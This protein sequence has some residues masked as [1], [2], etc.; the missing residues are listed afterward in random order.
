M[1]LGLIIYGRLDTLS[2]GYLYDRRLVAYLRGQGD[3]VEIISLPWSGYGRH[4]TH[5]FSRSLFDRLRHAS[6]D[7]LLQDE[8]NHPS[9]FWM[10]QRLREATAYPLISIVHHLRAS[11][12]RPAW[13]NRA[14]GWVEG[15]Y[16]NTVDGFIYNSQTTKTAVTQRLRTQKPSVIAYPAGDRFAPT[17]A[18]AEIA[19]RAQEEGPLRLVFVGNLIP[20]KGLHTLLAALTLLPPES[21]ELIVVGETAVNPTYA[22]TI[23]RQARQLNGPVRF[24]G[25]I[26]DA[27]LAQQL[28]QS[29]LLVVPSDYEGFGI[30]YLEGMGFGLPAIASTAGAAREIITDGVDGFLVGVGETAVLAN[31]IL[32]LHKDR[33]CLTQMG[34]AALKRYHA[35]PTWD[36]SMAKIRQF[37]LSQT[38]NRVFMKN[39]VSPM[40]G[41]NDDD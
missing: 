23:E 2:G 12:A 10:N 9:L 4:L 22:R 19:S 25:A 32:T 34:A 7:G 40:Q 27:E 31:R 18:P 37:L 1:H 14:Y 36:D 21:W 11:E 39:P 20:R 38:R 6:F 41:R 33:A 15:Q 26:S 17:V 8:L 16:L 24:L 35:H 29:Q 13:Q 3:T 5:N 30:V 28:K